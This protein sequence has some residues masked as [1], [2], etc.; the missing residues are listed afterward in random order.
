MAVR[1]GDIDGNGRGDYLCIEKDGRVTGFIHNDDDS[2][3]DVG[4][5]KVAQDKDRANLR[6]ADVNGDGKADMLWV[7]K[8][9]GDATVWYSRGRGNPADNLG[10]SFH[11]D[12]TN[13]AVYAGNVAGTCMYY[14][15]LDGNGRADQHSIENSL[16]NT[17]E[18]SFNPSCGLTDRTG[19]DSGGV[20]NPNLPV[21]PGSD[22]DG[23]DGGGDGN[24]NGN[25]GGNWPPVS[26]YYPNPKDDLPA[27]SCEPA[28][29]YST[30]DKIESQAGTIPLFCGPVQVLPVLVKMLQDATDQY[31]EILADHYDYYFGLYAN[32]VSDM[33]PGQ[34]YKYVEKA[35]DDFT[36]MVP[37]KVVCCTSCQTKYPGQNCEYC[38]NSQC[39]PSSPYGEKFTHVNVSEPCPPDLAR[40]GVTDPQIEGSA[41]DLSVYWTL[42][43]DQADAFFDGAVEAVG[44]VKDKI[45]FTRISVMNSHAIP[46]SE[47]ALDFYARESCAWLD[48]WLNYPQL[49]GFTAKDVINPKESV[50][51]ALG[52]TATLK[53]DLT[54][55]M[56]RIKVGVYDGYPEDVVDAVTLP[57]FMV[58]EAITAM[59]N[60]VEIGKKIDEQNKL[61]FLLFFLSAIFFVIPF[62]GE[63]LGSVAELASLGRVLT[64]I[65]EAGNA[66]LD[67]YGV[68]Q[69]PA[70]APL[71]I[72]GLVLGVK[73]IRDKETATKAADLRRAM[74]L[75][76]LGKLSPNIA[77]KMDQVGL[78]V[79]KD[80]RSIPLCIFPRYK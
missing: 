24:G 16:E 11:W 65:G 40:R 20:V 70:S 18:T 41:S 13:G 30:L 8:F 57:I 1:F 34:F 3:E 63:A 7:D 17:A 77:R 80:S 46:P 62:V 38:D 60:A 19:D 51:K 25:G 33:A 42:R 68:V 39:N 78:V 31:N 79:S 71:A 9:T 43:D 54:D 27:P 66:A 52:N 61:D 26:Y 67:I 53:D 50:S 12:M 22:D 21:Q 35:R 4:Q 23:G 59:Q 6:W 29:D 75:E 69:D 2:W 37:E 76:T 56:W 48:W 64:W 49:S 5:I 14:P 10:S 45:V 28:G 58:Q 32:M 73:G 44:P 72:L 55:A 47:C 74:S 36:C 15:D